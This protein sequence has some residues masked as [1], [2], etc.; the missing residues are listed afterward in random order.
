MLGTLRVSKLTPPIVRRMPVPISILRRLPS[1]LICQTESVLLSRAKNP[2][3]C[4]RWTRSAKVKSCG[5]PARERA[6]L[7]AESNGGPAADEKNIYVA[8]SDAQLD[9]NGQVSPKGG[10]GLLALQLAD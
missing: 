3:S 8:V 5:R 9:Q 2:A 4:M 6:V 7:S 10:G 1:S